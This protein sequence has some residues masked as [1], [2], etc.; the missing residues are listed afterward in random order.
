MIWHLIIR[1]TWNLVYLISQEF[2]NCSHKIFEKMI[3]QKYMRKPKKLIEM[4]FACH[5]FDIHWKIGKYRGKVSSR[6]LT[7]FT[8]ICRKKQ[9][10]PRPPTLSFANCD[11]LYFHA[12]STRNTMS[13]HPTRDNNWGPQII[14]QMCLGVWAWYHH[15][16]AGGG[17][18]GNVLSIKAWGSWIGLI[19][20]NRGL[21]AFLCSLFSK[22]CCSCWRYDKW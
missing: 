20:T 4:Y 6:R 8:T 2:A 12:P 1:K 21:I 22:S 7:F 15:L 11:T 16:G 13:A 19:K 14:S 5:A 3:Y 9:T 17:R 18:R 10:L